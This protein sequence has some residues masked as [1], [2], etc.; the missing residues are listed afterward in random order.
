MPPV[1]KGTKNRDWGMKE[2]EEV[3]GLEKRKV[4]S[5]ESGVVMRVRGARGR[6]ERQRARRK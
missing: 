6:G 3:E 2:W 5:R 4:E 1:K